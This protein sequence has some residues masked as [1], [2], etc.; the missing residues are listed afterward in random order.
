MIFPERW[1]RDFWFRAVLSSKD[2][3]FLI[4]AER[5]VVIYHFALH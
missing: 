1:P 2:E 5:G 3:F 4:L